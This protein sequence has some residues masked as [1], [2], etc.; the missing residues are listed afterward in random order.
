[1]PSGRPDRGAAGDLRR[2]RCPSSCVPWAPSSSGHMGDKKMVCWLPI[3]MM[4][5]ATFVIGLLLT[6]EA[7]GILAP[8]LLLC[9][10]MVQSFSAS[11]EHAGAAT[12][13]SPSTPCPT[14]AA[15]TARSSC[16]DGYGP[17][18]RLGARHV[19][20]HDRGH[21]SSFQTEWGW[22]ISFL[23]AYLL[24]SSR[25]TSV[26]ACPTRRYQEMQ[27]KLEAKGRVRRQTHRFAHQAPAA[28]AGVLA[29]AC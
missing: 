11:G 28:F 9:L 8:I 19:H 14:T 4:S 2:V 20:V 23:L 22:R 18:H 24:D 15:C 1:M 5:A 26:P 25:T 17:A 21:D 16:F 3:L 10:R 12:F 13:P 6:F 27:E 7:V 29:P